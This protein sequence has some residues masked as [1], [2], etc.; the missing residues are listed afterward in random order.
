MK[1]CEHSIY[2]L[3]LIAYVTKSSGYSNDNTF[4][5]TLYFFS[6]RAFFLDLSLFRFYSQNSFSS[7]PSSDSR[8]RK[9]T[10]ITL[11]CSSIHAVIQSKVAVANCTLFSVGFILVVAK[12][13]PQRLA[14]VVLALVDEMHFRTP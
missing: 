11:Y 4:W 13:A 10:K 12:L 5:V 3:L 7:R 2:S 1:F 14:R 9:A 8:S 6:S